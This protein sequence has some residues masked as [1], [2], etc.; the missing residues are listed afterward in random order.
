M[1]T[2]GYGRETRSALKLNCVDV[3]TTTHHPLRRSDPMRK[4]IAGEVIGTLLGAFVILFA[5]LAVHFDDRESR[6][7]Q[8]RW[9]P[10]FTRART[11]AQRT[12]KPILVVAI[13]G[14]KTGKC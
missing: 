1:T 2:S 8:I 10:D 11:E 14:G 3:C 4:G 12:G 13:A 7:L 9:Q 5:V 6:H